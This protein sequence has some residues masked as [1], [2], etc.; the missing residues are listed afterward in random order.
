[1]IN[2]GLFTSLADDWAT[3]QALFDDLNAEFGFTLDACA[4]AVNHKCERY[5]DLQ[6]DGLAQVWEGVVW[7]NPPYG[8]TI[9][10]W[11][12]KALQEARGGNCGYVDTCS[13]RYFLVA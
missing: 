12:A 7:C 6:A 10:L 2:K 13:H 8:R 4:N 11:V 9:K 3:P 5:F 1:V